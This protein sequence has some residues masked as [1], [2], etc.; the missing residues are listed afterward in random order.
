MSRILVVDDNPM[1]L[2]LTRAT[3]ELSGFEV[4]TAIN[5]SEAL[6][7]A[8]V[9]SVDLILM[10]LRMPVMDGRQSMTALRANPVTAHIPIVVLTASAMKGER[11]LMLTVGFDGY[12]DKPIDVRTFADT[13]SRLLKSCSV[14]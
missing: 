13:V 5:G 1:N 4:V 8:E 11:E 7:I 3:L 2:E 10:D 14:R 9:E 6:H 12:I